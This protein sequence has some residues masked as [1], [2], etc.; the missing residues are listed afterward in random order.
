M[1]NLYETNNFYL[2]VQESGG[3]SKKVSTTPGRNGSPQSFFF[4]V[5]NKGTV[6]HLHVIKARGDK[7]NVKGKIK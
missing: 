6:A 7:R 3:F 2:E 5:L 4:I 1:S